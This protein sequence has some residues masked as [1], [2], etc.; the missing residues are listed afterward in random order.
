L[1]LCSYALCFPLLLALFP[2]CSPLL[3][4]K[5]AMHVLEKVIY[6]IRCNE[7]HVLK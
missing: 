3:N 4:E 1:S 5:R 7:F 6:L 2:D